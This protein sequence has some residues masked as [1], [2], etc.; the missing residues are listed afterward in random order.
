M[1]VA[2]ATISNRQRELAHRV[3]S[4]LEITLYWNAADN[5]TSLEVRHLATE[6]T[7]RVAVPAEQALDAFYHPLAHVGYTIAP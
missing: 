1:T 2:T 5:R 3:S 7:L 4:G 6:M